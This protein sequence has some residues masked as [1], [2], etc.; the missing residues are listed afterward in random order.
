ME[1]KEFGEVIA[2]E[3]KSALGAEYL[4][5]YQD[6]TK[7]NGVIY[8]A[9]TIRKKDEN[10]APTIYIDRMFE[11]YERGAV[12]SGIVDDVLGMYR[13]S[14]P[15]KDM[16]IDFF[17]DFSKVSD[18]LFYKVVN[19]KKNKEKLKEVPIK[20]V[21]DLAIVPLCLYQNEQ[22]GNGSITIQNS[23]LKVWEITKEELWENVS[24]NAP[25]VAPPKI[26]D[27]MDFIAKM[28]GQQNDLE[29]FCGMYVLTNEGENFGAGSI[30]YPG[31]LKGIADDHECDLF[32][33]PSSVHECI[34]I[35][36]AAF[37]MDTDS[38]REIIREVNRTAL[39]E[40]DILSDNLYMYDRENDRFFIVK[41]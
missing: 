28:T 32:I 39:A 8:H 41:E 6:V 33:I 23:H 30:L 12:L 13:Q 31:L 35:P 3:V 37:A 16:D 17:Y 21:L 7:N 24:E 5:D 2:R 10:I 9:I 38:M 27:L 4:T 29:D 15:R 22:I 11:K 20:R 19:Y 14:V 34:I 25:R 40:E 1:I 26:K 18:K 36:D